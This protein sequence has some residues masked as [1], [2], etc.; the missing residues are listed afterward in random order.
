MVSAWNDPDEEGDGLDEGAVKYF[1]M[2]VDPVTSYQW[3]EEMIL[4]DI[5]WKR[6]G[7]ANIVAPY[8]TSGTI[9]YEDMKQVVASHGI[10]YSLMVWV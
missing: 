9:S 8:M 1:S 2:F 4:G 6:L 5:T 7:P 10:Q 3:G